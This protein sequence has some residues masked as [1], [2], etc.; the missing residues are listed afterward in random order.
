MVVDIVLYDSFGD[1]AFLAQKTIF[2][3][4]YCVVCEVAQGR[5]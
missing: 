2:F 4:L 1:A 5:V 3:I